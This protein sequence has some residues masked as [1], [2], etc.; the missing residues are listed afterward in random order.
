MVAVLGNPQQVVVDEAARMLR[1]MTDIVAKQADVIREQAAII[2]TQ[3]D[4]IEELSREVSAR[5]EP[6][7]PLAIVLDRVARSVIDGQYDQM[8]DD[9][10]RLVRMRM[11]AVLPTRAVN[12]LTAGV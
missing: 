8:S 4:R 1:E 9:G 3:S 5:L 12:A 6:S 2:A 7:A 11:L 10:R